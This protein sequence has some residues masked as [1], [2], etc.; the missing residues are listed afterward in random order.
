MLET[1][2]VLCSCSDIEAARRIARVLVEDRL[3]ACASTVPAV[4][5]VYRWHENIETATETLLLV[6]TTAESFPKL[7]ERILELHSYDTPEIIALPIV[8]GL[9]K[10]LHWLGEQ[11][12]S[13][14]R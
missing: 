4:E 10:Y 3:A 8:A 1:I 14:D 11:V 9:E 12:S 6:K 13:K 2:V 5:S 7:R